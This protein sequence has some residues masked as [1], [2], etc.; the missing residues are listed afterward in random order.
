MARNRKNEAKKLLNG[1]RRLERFA[2]RTD[3]Q[4]FY[5]DAIEQNFITLVMGPAGSGK[6]L[7]SMVAA[8]N[9]LQ[10][11]RCTKLYLTRPAVESC[12][13]KLGALPGDA[14]E[15]IDPYMI[16]LYESLEKILGKQQCQQMIERGVIEVVPL[17]FMRGRTLDDAYVIMDEGQNSTIEQMKML[18]TRLGAGSKMIVTG[19]LEQSDISNHYDSRKN[20]RRSGLEDAVIRFYDS[21]DDVAVVLLTEDDIQRHPSIKRIIRL[22]RQGLPEDMSIVEICDD[23]LGIY[24]DEEDE[25]EDPQHDHPF[26]DDEVFD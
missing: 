16:P 7:L 23:I 22:Y 19:D 13:E 20:R 11:G 15:K 4:Q 12:G 18:M 9:A 14:V 21:H 5:V 8:C 24:C 10:E 25:A 6:T 3:N 2:A 26:E 1:T 17:A